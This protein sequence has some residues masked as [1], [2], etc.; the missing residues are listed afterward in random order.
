MT[1][2][3]TGTFKNGQWH[4]GKFTKGNTSYDGLFESGMN[5]KFIVEWLESGNKYDGML[6]NEKLHGEGEMIYKEGPIATIEGFWNAGELERCVLLT[7]R[8]GSTATNYQISTG[9][10]VGQGSVKVG[11]STYTGTWDESGLLNG[12]A[13]ITNDNESKF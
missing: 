11:P 3:F 1:S 13:T 9:M 12:E 4:K 10:L 5:G 7:K 8:D 6:L 2:F